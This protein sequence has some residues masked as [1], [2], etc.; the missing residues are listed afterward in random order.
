VGT[1]GRTVYDI[2]ADARF[3]EAI[4]WQ[5]AAALN[6]PLGVLRDGPDAPRNERRR[7]R[8]EIIAKYAQRY[9]A[10]NDTIG[11]FGPMCWVRVDA[12]APPMAGGHGPSLIRTRRVFFEWWA[13]AVLAEHIGADPAVKPW[14]PVAL[15]PHLTV[16]GRSLLAPG[17]PP[18]RL[19][20]GE[21]AVLARCDGRRPA[22][23]VAADAAE[24]PGSGV[25]RAEDVYPMLERFAGQGVLRWE[26]VLPMNLAA[27]DMLREQ[28]DRIGAGAGARARGELDRLVRARDLLAAADGAEAVAG[29]VAH[30]ES[31]FVAITGRAARHRD[32]QTYAGRTLVHLDAARDASFTFGG[33]VLA[34]LA[35]MEPLLRSTR[36][37]TSTLAETYREELRARYAELAEELGTR[38]VPFAQLLFVAQSSLFGADRPA[39]TVVAEFGRRWARLLGLDGVPAGTECVRLSSAE[40][41]AAV[42][43]AFPATGPGWPMGRLHSPDVHLCAGSAQELARGEFFVVLGEL[44]IGIP[45]LDTD[46]FR[47]GLDD[48]DHLVEAMRADVPGGRVLPLVP[49]DWPRQCARNADW[50]LGPREVQLGFTA[51]PGADPDRL[52]PITSIVVSQAHRTLT[53]HGPDGRTW[54]VIELVADFL[55][56]HALDTWKLTGL[57]GHTPRVMVDDLVLL[58]RSWRSTVA[59]TGL[60]DVTG[61]R[62]RYLAV[63]RWCRQLG[64]PQRVFVRVGTEIKPCFID[65]TSPVYTRIL[66][67]L[68]RSARRTGGEATPVTVSEMLPTPDQ[69][70]LTDRDGRRY[71]SELRLH[72]SD[73]VPGSAEPST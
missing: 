24:L 12:G 65:L 49:A 72:L 33:D 13:L 69:A 54:P 30:L 41:S 2:S 29:A 42:D 52:V 39:D 56:G 68:M 23:R 19:S 35:P 67:T 7:R 14:L 43:E 5:N 63:R 11:F 58:R 8:E 48:P 73:P 17:R 44:H 36:W 4:A 22:V 55:G 46:F 27:E 60:A 50:M 10:K 9:A 38:E 57:D 28:I 47:V 26:F 37:L 15:Q 51:A 32:G 21:A 59:Q 62:E 53:A 34:A 25:R 61:E 40:L 3:R 71:T 1:L 31:E 66:C 20:P 45:A 70:W 16:R 18:R 6:G 64:L